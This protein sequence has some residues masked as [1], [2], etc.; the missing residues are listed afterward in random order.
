GS[1]LISPSTIAPAS[2]CFD[3]L[4]NEKKESTVTL[5]LATLAY[6]E[7]LNV[8]VERYR[9]KTFA[10]ACRQLHVKHIR[11]KPSTPQNQRQ[12]RALLPGCSPRTGLP[13]R[14]RARRAASPGIVPLA[15]SP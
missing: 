14:T 1:L 4:P 15:A 5:L 13:C 6:Y 8:K 11:T 10:R 7:S 3:I 9:S 2:A 12:S